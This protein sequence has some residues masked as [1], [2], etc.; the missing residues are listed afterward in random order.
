MI[1]A[2]VLMRGGV[3]HRMLDA[4]VVMAVTP[5]QEFFEDEEKGDAGDERDAHFVHVLDARAF[6]RVGDQGQE[7]GA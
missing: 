7:R 5:E 1:E 2:V 6:D 4:M 3:T